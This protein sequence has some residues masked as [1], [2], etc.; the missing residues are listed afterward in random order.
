[1]TMLLF[2]LS[3]WLC[4]RE[5]G[6]RPMVCLL[7][8]LAAGLN[9]HAFSIACWGLGHWVIAFSMVF[10]AISALVSKSIQRGWVRGILAG[11]AVGISLMEGFDVG[12]INSLYVG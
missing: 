11:L 9:M 8:G 7:G 6:F 12:A 3:V 5:L 2:G 10:L 1:F 4:F